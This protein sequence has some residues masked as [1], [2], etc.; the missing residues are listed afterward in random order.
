MYLNPTCTQTAPCNRIIHYCSFAPEKSSEAMGLSQ[1]LTAAYPSA[2]VVASQSVQ[3]QHC[4]LESRLVTG[5][6]TFCICHPRIGFPRL[7]MAPFQIQSSELLLC[8]MKG[9]GIDS[10]IPSQ[11]CLFCMEFDLLC[12]FSHY[13]DRSFH[14][15]LLFLHIFIISIFVKVF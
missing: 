1:R 9:P 12:F 8:R 3:W 4:L 10:S 2:V 7:K 14:Y 11:R 15:V 5:V 6:T 13:Q